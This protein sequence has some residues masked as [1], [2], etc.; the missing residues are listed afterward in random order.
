MLNISVKLLLFVELDGLMF[1]FTSY[2]RNYLL[3]EATY[4]GMDLV[5]SFYF[6]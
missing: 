4:V 3:F 2:G 5:F 1:V 6:T